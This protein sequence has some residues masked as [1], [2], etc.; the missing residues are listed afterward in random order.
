MRALTGGSTAGTRSKAWRRLW[1]LVL[2]G[3][4]LTAVGWVQRANTEPKAPPNEQILAEFREGT[5]TAAGYRAAHATR[6]KGLAK[7]QGHVADTPESRRT[8]L[9][10]LIRTHLLAGEAIRRGYAGADWEVMIA[11]R[12]ALI[13]ERAR[14]YDP[15]AEE[16]RGFFEVER[17]RASGRESSRFYA[18]E[19]VSVLALKCTTPGEVRRLAAELRG[20]KRYDTAWQLGLAQRYGA[21]SR[22]GFQGPFAR[23]TSSLP[24][25]VVKAAFDLKEPKDVAEPVAVD[26]SHYLV[27]LTNRDEETKLER[28]AKEIRAE[29]V[30]LRKETIGDAL[31]REARGK[32]NIVIAQEGPARGIF[33]RSNAGRVAAS[34]NGAPLTT[35]S[36]ERFAQ[37]VDLPLE[38]KAAIRALDER[39]KLAA[40]TELAIET[41][42]LA[43]SAVEQGHVKSERVRRVLAQ[44]IEQDEATAVR[45]NAVDESAI[46]AAFASEKQLFMTTQKSSVYRAAEAAFWFVA[47]P[48]EA[49]ARTLRSRLEQAPSARE[50]EELVKAHSGSRVRA[51]AGRAPARVPNAVLK[52]AFGNP[53]VG[54]WSEPLRLADRTFL[55]LPLEYK[56][57]TTLAMARPALTKTLLGHARRRAV[58]ALV[59]KLRGEAGLVVH[60]E[61]LAGVQ[62]DPPPA[63]STPATV[64]PET[65]IRRPHGGG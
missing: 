44:A 2:A 50:L 35:R 51:F 33:A 8:L 55:V 30:R 60:E 65:L 5:I 13:S 48:S 1:P 64:G 38:R 7:K 20:A 62:L 56:P 22:G 34:V 17:K 15:T 23:D 27:M 28:V 10:Q 59:A 42:L 53:L 61:R 46:R 4:A 52:Y 3:S 49:A 24:S 37:L 21:K 18:P 41:K 25:P 12:E 16:I 6:Q 63:P 58:D 47:A 39:E 11:L 14:S 31:A 57:E 40:F 19:R 26:G 9:D 29:L 43:A 54:R 45:S 36:V 32:A